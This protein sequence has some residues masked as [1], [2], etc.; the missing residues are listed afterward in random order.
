MA[1]HDH[2]PIQIEYHEMSWLYF[3]KLENSFR[4][5][6]Q[7]GPSLANTKAKSKKEWLTFEGDETEATRDSS[8]TVVDNHGV[9]EFT[10]FLEVLLHNGIVRVPAET[11]DK[12]FASLQKVALNGEDP[13]KENI[14]I[15]RHRWDLKCLG[16]EI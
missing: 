3:F 10:E 7:N 2:K 14:V 1:S 15:C 16:Q 12:K 8:S 6:V 4:L 11:T 13:S 5:L 9:L